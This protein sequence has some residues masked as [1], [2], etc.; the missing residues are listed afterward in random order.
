M[1][2]FEDTAAKILEF[3]VTNELTHCVDYCNNRM[4]AQ[5]SSYMAIWSK[6]RF[7]V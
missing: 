2:T 1:L 6:D 5:R 4:W 7:G 3:V